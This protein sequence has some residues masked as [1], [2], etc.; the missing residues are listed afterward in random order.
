VPAGA[1]L[2]VD[3]SA[4]SGLLT[5]V[6]SRH[7]LI[8]IAREEA[9]SV[10]EGDVII[11]SGPLSSEG[12]QDALSA[13]VGAERLAFF[14]AAAPIV[15]ASTIDMERVFAASRW[16]KGG[17]ADYLNC[18]LDRDTYERLVSEL[19]S[20]QRTHAKEFER[21]EL[22]Q[23]C[24]PVE[25][26]ARTGPDALR[27]GA[28]KPIGLVDPLTGQRPW[29]VVQLRP[30]NRAGSAYNLVGFQ[31]NLTF[32]EQDRVFR[33]V[34]GLE[35]AEFLRHGVMHRNTLHV[36]F[37]LIAPLD[38]HVSGKQRRYAAYSER[39]TSDRTEA[40]RARLDLRLQSP[41][42]GSAAIAGESI[43]GGTT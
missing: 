42:F 22:F 35:R 41:E 38:A 40:L 31:T 8:S 11:A 10:P 6:L 15:E 32:G 29:A 4:F 25:E 30:E 18:P 9:V 14:D 3:R 39:A 19:V 26:I 7:P 27:Y 36:N 28:L 16:D 17:G 13:L 21:R 23:A 43:S 2:A 20:A 37:G 1:A 5:D 12:L 33:L 34:P 24:Q